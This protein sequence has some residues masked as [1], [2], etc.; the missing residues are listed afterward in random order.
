MKYRN[1][2]LRYN[3][4]TKKTNRIKINKIQVLICREINISLVHIL[5]HV[6]GGFILVPRHFRLLLGAGLV[7]AFGVVAAALRLIAGLAQTLLSGDVA[8]ML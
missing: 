2:D 7:R 6:S 4:V 3:Y 5:G 8:W 1:T